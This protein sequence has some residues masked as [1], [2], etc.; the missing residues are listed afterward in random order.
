MIMVSFIRTNYV[1]YVEDGSTLGRFLFL[2]SET[3][4]P[5]GES[6]MVFF[7]KITILVNFT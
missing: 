3:D 5:G 2:G 6:K 1:I 7:E 4:T